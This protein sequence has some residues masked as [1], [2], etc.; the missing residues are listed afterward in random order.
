MSFEKPT[1]GDWLTVAIMV[2]ILSFTLNNYLDYRANSSQPA[3]RSSQ[4]VLNAKRVAKPEPTKQEE[5]V[6]IDINETRRLNGHQSLELDFTLM[7]N[8]EEYAKELALTCGQLEH[9]DLE[10]YL[11]GTVAGE[12][13][14]KYGENLAL[15]MTSIDSAL[16]QLKDSS[17]HYATMNGDYT[18]AGVAVLQSTPTQCHGAIFVVQHFAKIEQ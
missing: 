3:A 10:P 12:S 1:I 13:I 16:D 17:S 2:V 5:K 6:I 11:E 14:L 8:A 15:H 4:S 7:Q 9:S 18:H